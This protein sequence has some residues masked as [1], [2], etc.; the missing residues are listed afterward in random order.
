M[1]AH[2]IVLLVIIS[3]AVIK[4]IVDIGKKQDLYYSVFMFFLLIFA[5]IIIIVIP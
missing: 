3:I 1:A 5:L 4:C 2:K